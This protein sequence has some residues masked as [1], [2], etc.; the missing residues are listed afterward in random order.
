M[1]SSFYFDGDGS[2][3]SAFNTICNKTRCSTIMVQV[4]D[5]RYD[6]AHYLAPAENLVTLFVPSEIACLASS[7]GRMSLTLV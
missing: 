5:S 1:D 2:W 7:P 6:E 3:T 4:Q